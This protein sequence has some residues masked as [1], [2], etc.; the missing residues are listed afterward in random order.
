MLII[1]PS[2]EKEKIMEAFEISKF[3]IRNT[4]F[5]Y[6]DRYYK[7]GRSEDDEDIGTSICGYESAFYTDIVGKYI[8]EKLRN[9]KFMMVKYVKLYCDDG[10][11][12]FDKAMPMVEI[13]QWLQNFQR[14]VNTH[15]EEEY[16][17]KK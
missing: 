14:N 9:K 5:Y 17:E 13:E 7:Y 16:W 6:K 15:P 10:I 2:K 12:V 3:G 1:T 8:L 4:I 11:I